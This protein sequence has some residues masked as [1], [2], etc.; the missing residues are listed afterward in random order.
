LFPE[1]G[2]VRLRLAES[3]VTVGEHGA[4][5]NHYGVALTLLPAQAASISSAIVRAYQAWGQGVMRQGQ[6]MEAARLF[7]TALQLDSSN[8]ALYFALGQAEFH[9]RALEAAIE[10]FEAALTYEPGLLHEVDP[11]LAKAQA[12]RGGPQTVVIDFP[13]GATRIEVSVL[14]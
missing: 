8:G 7:R 12:L 13:P 4:A 6:F 11:Y 5:I 9:R 2:D 10:A 14:I 3:L 1:R